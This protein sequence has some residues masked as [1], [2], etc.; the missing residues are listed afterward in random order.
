MTNR[1]LVRTMLCLSIS[2]LALSTTGQSAQPASHACYQFGCVEEYECGVGPTI[3][4]TICQ[5]TTTEIC[6]GPCLDRWGSWMACF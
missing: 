6:G 2:V 1:M 4:P 5:H 3:C